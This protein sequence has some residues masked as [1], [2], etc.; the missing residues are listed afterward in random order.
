MTYPG[1]EQVHR[2]YDVAGRLVAVTDWSG[3]RTSFRLDDNGAVT[4]TALPDG[5]TIQST[6]DNQGALTARTVSGTPLALG[7]TRDALGRATTA[8]ET[9]F[10]GPAGTALTYDPLGQLATT[11]ATATGSDT[12]GSPTTVNGVPQTFDPALALTGRATAP[13]P[14][15]VT[16]S[17]RGE[18]SGQAAANGT[19]TTRSP[20]SASCGRS[21]GRG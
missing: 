8:T 13:E 5:R 15:T 16:T 2:E 20:G 19:R 7:V 10:G 6:Y 18:R 21:P 1:G 14:T 3:R 12:T 9:G 4:A 17:A 11:G